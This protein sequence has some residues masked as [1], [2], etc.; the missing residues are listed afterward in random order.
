M[1]IF[2]MQAEHGRFHGRYFS[3]IIQ[4]VVRT[5]QA[6][7]TVNLGRDHRICQRPIDTIAVHN[8]FD[9]LLGFAI[10]DQDSIDQLP[11]GDAAFEKQWNDQYDVRRLGFGDASFCACMNERMED[12]LEPASSRRIRKDLFTQAPA[13]ETAIG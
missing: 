3:S 13:I 11:I 1:Q 8:T 2:F 5:L 10:D 6:A 4:H 9:L 7:R 12:G